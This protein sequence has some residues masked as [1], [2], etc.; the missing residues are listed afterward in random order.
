MK[1]C[2]HFDFETVLDRH[3]HDSIAVDGLGLKGVPTPPKSGFSTIPM[4]IADM[5]IP[6][7]PGI[8]EALRE[9]L[10]HPNFGYFRPS[11]AYFQTIHDWHQRVKKGPEFSSEM[12]GFHNGVL[13]ALATAIRCFTSP[14]DAVLVH[15]P[16]YGGFIKTLTGLGRRIVYSPLCA[17]STG[18]LRMDYGDMEKK[19]REN[20]IHFAIFCSPHNPSGRA[21]D[22]DEIALALDL[23]KR[24]D[25]L[26]VSDEIWSDL[27]LGG[28]QHICT[29]SIGD[30]AKDQVIAIYAPS[31][32]F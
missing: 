22:R 14:G 28:R 9:R 20:Q 5:N 24:N 2:T 16:C 1:E 7:Y 17:D 3:D 29:Q 27:Y 8:Q 25:C 13:G 10:S 23:F 6:C 12:I 15:S 31:K 4:W 26:V 30:W 11:E 18:I 19:I 32:T 21:F